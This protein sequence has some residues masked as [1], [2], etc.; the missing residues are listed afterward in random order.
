MAQACIT[1]S[2]KIPKSLSNLMTRQ[3]LLKAVVWK[4]EN[5]RVLV[6]M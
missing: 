4:S 5:T 6:Y 3:A 1:G 2:Q